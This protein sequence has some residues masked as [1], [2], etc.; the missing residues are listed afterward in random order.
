MIPPGAR[1]IDASVM[2]ER[3]IETREPSCVPRAARPSFILVVHNSLE[4]VGHVAAP[5]LSL[6]EAEPGAMGHMAM[7]EP[8]SEGR[9]GLK[10]RDMWQRQSSPMQEGEV[11]N[12]E[13]VAAP[14]PTSVGRRGLTL[15]DTW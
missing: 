15:R 6:G 5:E 3:A 14:E 13:H 1:L 7:P 11:R 8:T 2:R 10:L 4:A 9:R 12:H